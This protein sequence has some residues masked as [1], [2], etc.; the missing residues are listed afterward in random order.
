MYK[1]YS[2][3]LNTYCQTVAPIAEQDKNGVLQ[4]WQFALKSEIFCWK[5]HF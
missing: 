1:T 4:I 5:V 3:D 2:E